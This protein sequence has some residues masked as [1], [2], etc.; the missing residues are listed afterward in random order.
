MFYLRGMNGIFIPSVQTEIV[1][2]ISGT[3]YMAYHSV[4]SHSISI[5]SNLSTFTTAPL[6]RGGASY[7][8]YQKKSKE[9]RLY[10]HY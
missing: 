7:N 9:G 1:H 3:P 8:G 6:L 5:T 4:T 2:I 10:G